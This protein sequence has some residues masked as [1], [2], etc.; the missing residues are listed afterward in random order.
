MRARSSSTTERSPAQSDAATKRM[1]MRIRAN[2]AMSRRARPDLG[3]RPGRSAVRLA[4][5]TQRH[6]GAAVRRERQPAG[7]PARR[8]H[9]SGDARSARATTASP[10]TWRASGWW[11]RSSSSGT[12]RPTRWSREFD[13]AILKNDTQASVRRAVRAVQD[14]EAAAAAGR[15]SSRT[16]RCM[17]GHAVTDVTQDANSASVDR[18]R[19]GRRHD[20]QGR[21]RDRRRRRPQHR[22]QAI[23]HRLRRLHLARALHRVH[24]A[25]R[26]REPTAATAPQLLRR[27]RRLVQLLQGL[28]R[29]PARALAHGVPDRLRRRPKQN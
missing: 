21:L 16:S 27:P 13:H 24:D 1:P 26:F 4:A 17:Y 18:A 6:S 12:G 25:V 23:R 22:A 11:R 5:R 19:T 28:G 7:R 10:T 15:R 3:R 20:P 29:R 9:A 8:H 14:R 2:C